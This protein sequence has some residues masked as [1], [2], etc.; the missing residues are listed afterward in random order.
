[1]YDVTQVTSERTTDCGATC[2]RM[3]LLYYGI[4]V[5]LDTLIEELDISLV[6]CTGKDL[7]RVGR[8]HGLDMTAYKVDAAELMQ[9]DRP[10]IIHWIFTHWVMF[11][12]I[13]DCDQVVIAD[14]DKGRYGID[15]GSFEALYSGTALFAGAP[16]DGIP[17]EDN[18]VA[19]QLFTLCGHTYRALSNIARGERVQEGYNA[20]VVA[21]TDMINEINSESEE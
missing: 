5:D 1:M 15:R 8:A 11:C 2:M 10:A 16:L 14:P 3:L 19:G 6:G 17:A 21:L 12:G 18:Y 9:L 7:L 20:E 13:N 4:D